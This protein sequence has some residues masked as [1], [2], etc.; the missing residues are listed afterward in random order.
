LVKNNRHNSIV[1][2][3]FVNFALNPETALPPSQL[4]LG[5]LFIFSFLGLITFLIP[6]EDYGLRIKKFGPFEFE[7]I[8][9]TQKNEYL[10]E[11]EDLKE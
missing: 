11:I 1:G 10:K 6:L 3:A 5:P 2:C 8:L 7:E 4:G 9:T